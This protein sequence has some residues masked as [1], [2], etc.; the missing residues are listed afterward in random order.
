[1][2]DT[3]PSEKEIVVMLKLYLLNMYFIFASLFSSFGKK[4]NAN[5]DAGKAEKGEK[6]DLILVPFTAFLQHTARQPCKQAGCQQGK[7]EGHEVAIV[8]NPG[9]KD[10]KHC[11]HA[12]TYLIT[13]VQASSAYSTQSRR[14]L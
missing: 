8:H 7:R 12:T 4:V 11:V 6:I 14:K 2:N 9:T 10:I 1:M 13:P 3:T 5:E